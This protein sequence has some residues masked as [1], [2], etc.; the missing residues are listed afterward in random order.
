M[1]TL[2]HISKTFTDTRQSV[3]AVKD[4]SLSVAQGEIFGI[5]GASGAGKSTLVRCINLLERPETGK[6][7]LGDVELSAL[8][9]KALRAY[10]RKIGMIFQHFNLMASRTVMDNVLLP[11]K[12]LPLSPADARAKAQSLL[13][14]V[15]LS[16]KERAYPS[17]LSGGQKQRVAIA[18]ALAND[19]VLLL[20]DEAT[21]A[22]DP[23]TTLSILA[24]LKE[25]NRKLQ[26][27]I[28][29]I[30]HEMAVVKE[31]CQRV[32]IMEDGRVV[33][34]G[35]VFDIFSKPR[36]N[37]T[38]EFIDTTSPLNKI[39]RL[40]AQKSPVV[41]LQPGQRILKLKF[42]RKSASQALISEVS[43]RFN[44]DMSIIFGDIEIIADAPLGGL[45]VIM[46]GEGEQMLAAIAYLT[47]QDVDV[48]V[49]DRA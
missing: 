40:I 13:A 39:Y 32:A 14:L 2:E 23:Q 26:L 3:E 1:L 28:V 15:G 36:E 30:T 5:I 42:Q 9:E 18:R 7:T 37:V 48:E 22:L 44:V 29:I 27:S 49:I 46:G 43:R 25:L 33:E 12:D 6:V 35:D 4:V 38:R 16:D 34:M 20:C 31:I 17:Q 8:P 11:L 19:P 47:G 41:R 21:S 10:R 45:V 24:L